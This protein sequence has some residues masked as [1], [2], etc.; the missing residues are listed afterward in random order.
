V[1]LC[2]YCC[3]VGILSRNLIPDLSHRVIMLARLR[4]SSCGIRLRRR[5]AGR[6]GAR[7][8]TPRLGARY[9]DSGAW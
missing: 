9:R 8:Q 3:D 2:P 1:A 4:L 6:G 5:P 7:D